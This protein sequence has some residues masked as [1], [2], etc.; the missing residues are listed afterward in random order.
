M[1]KIALTIFTALIFIS[2]CK[3]Q[4]FVQTTDSIPMRDGK[5]LAA[6]IYLPSTPGTYPVILVQTP[7]NRLYYRIN[8]PLELGSLAGLPY[9]LVV[10]DWRGFYGSAA[11]MV[12]TPDRGK[13]GYDIVEWIATQTWSNG[14]IGT[15]GPSALGKIQFQTAKETPPHLTCCA[16]LV[17]GPQ[18]NYME[19]FPGGVYRK[20]YV[21]QLDNLGFGLSAFLLANP[22]YSTTWQ[23]VESANFY[24]QSINVPTF[25][26]GGWYDHNVEV[27]MQLFTGLQTSSPVAVRNQHKLM[28]GPW[29]HGG[30]GTAQVGTC[31]QGQLTY[32]EACGWSDSLAL[33]FFDYYLR[34]SANGW[35]SEPVVRYFQMGENTWQAT[36]T[37]PPTGTTPIKLFFNETSSLTPSLPASATASANITYDPHNPS[38]TVGGS[39]LRNDLQQGPYNQAPVVESRND[40]LIFTTPALSE[41]VVMKGTGRVHLFV[42]SNR[43]DTDFGYRLT[44]VYPDGRSMLLVDNIQRMRFR[45]GFL[46]SDTA[47]MQPGTVYEIDINIHD[48]A[49]TFLAGHKIRIDITSSNYPR[50]N[51]NL[52]N[53]GAMYTSGDTLTATNTVYFSNNKASFVELPLISYPSS[54]ADLFATNGDFTLFPN[55]ATESFSVTGEDYT[56]IDVYNLNGVKLFSKKRSESYDL[57][58]LP[59]GVYFV[60]IFGNGGICRRK[61]VKM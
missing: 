5:K 43:P 38:P 47:S 12:A 52:N 10:V 27:M 24:P 25:M 39:T 61:L 48:L 58:T 45:N 44:D 56:K 49:N 35:N 13:D 18:F 33:R 40:I 60:E 3:S 11:A 8:Q 46:T 51:N 17:A 14:K 2:L 50:F 54:I 53:G 7:Y 32:N 21:D 28:M 31:T 22:F 34:D 37:W 30:F 15:W 55:P 19:Y 23:Y 57:H 26:V 1:K 20:E 59:A 29:A 4:T 42:S 36:S 6:D 16:P 9:A 41:N